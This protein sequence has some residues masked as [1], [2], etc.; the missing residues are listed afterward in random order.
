M[1]TDYDC[2][3]ENE[4]HVTVENVLANLR[5]NSEN[6][7]RL[8]MAV[9]PRLKNGL[10]GEGRGAIKKGMNRFAVITAPD[11]RRPERRFALDY[12]LPGYF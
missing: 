1:A 3:R 4:E 10:R 5:M 11:R 8:L 7:G 9:L 2:W 6:A 12:L